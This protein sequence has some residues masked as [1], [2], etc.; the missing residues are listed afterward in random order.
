MEC[1]TVGSRREVRTFM[2]RIIFNTRQ[3]AQQTETFMEKYATVTQDTKP[4]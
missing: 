2:A 3:T 4:T 1:V